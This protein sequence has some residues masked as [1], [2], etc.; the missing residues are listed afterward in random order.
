MKERKRERKKKVE[1]NPICAI[2]VYLFN[3]AAL[4]GSE[5]CVSI[6][7]VWSSSLPCVCGVCLIATGRRG[8]G[9]VVY[10]NNRQNQRENDE[11]DARAQ[12]THTD[13]HGKEQRQHA[14]MGTKEG[15][16]WAIISSV[17]YV[18][19]RE[20]SVGRSVG[21][22]LSSG[23]WEKLTNNNNVGRRSVAGMMCVKFAS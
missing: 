23:G 7:K 13:T 2:I 4:A 15:V 11:E 18:C 6:I 14:N 16:D 1:G 17:V 5:D 19:V 9:G 12:C 21:R 10:E 8:G 22:S 20:R 3:A